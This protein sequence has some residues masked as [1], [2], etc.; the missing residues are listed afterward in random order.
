VL[1]GLALGSSVCAA[2]CASHLPP[3]DPRPAPG[4]IGEET[5]GVFCDRV[6]AQSLHE[7]LSGAS[8]LRV[9]HRD[10]ATGLFADAVDPSQLPAIPA[11]APQAAALERAHAVARIG[12]LARHRADLI[13][14]L[15]AVVPASATVLSRSGGA[16]GACA[17]GEVRPLS[18][19]LAAVLARMS[20]AYDDGTVPQATRSLG[21]LMNAFKA[22]PGAQAA[23]ERTNKRTGYRPE[24]VALGIVRPVLAYPGLRDMANATL[25]LVSPVGP[26]PQYPKLQAL[27]HTTQL[28]LAYASA[29]PYQP[30]LVTVQDA[31]LGIDRLS[32]PRTSLELLSRVMSTEDPAFGG[33]PSRYVVRRDVRGMAAVAAPGGVLPAPF[34]DANGDGLPD[35]DSAG[36]FVTSNGAPAPSP[37]LS[38]EVLADA[39]PRDA[40]GRALDGSGRLVYDFIDT[41]HIY[42]ASVVKNLL[43]M[44]DPDPAMH[45]E[46][47]MDALAGAYVVV[48]PKLGSPAAQKT[49][50][51]G[52][53]LAYDGFDTGHSPLVDLVYAVGQTLADSST[54]AAVTAAAW[55]FTNDEADLAEA[56]DAALRIKKTSDAHPEAVLQ[57]TS[58]LWDDLID[59][60]AQIADVTDD[61]GHPV[62]LEEMLAGLADPAAS[63]LSSTL[64][65]LVSNRD[66]IDYDRRDVNGPPMNV[67]A[68]L[69]GA[70]PQTPVDRT[71]SDAGFN[72][73]VF[74]RFLALIHDTRGVSVCNR[75]GAHVKALM[76]VPVFGGTVD[77][78][79]PDSPLV[80]PFWGKTSFGE[81]EVFKM[82]DMATFYVQ[83][84][85]G[86]AQYVLRDKLLRDG[87][88]IDPADTATTVQLL[89]QSSALTGY[90]PPGTTDPSLRTGF[91]TPPSS[92][93]L[94]TRPEWLNR[95]LFL[96]NGYAGPNGDLPIPARADAFSK[97][98][99]PDHAGTSVCPKREVDDPLSPSDPNYTPGGK[100]YLPDCQDGDWLDQ[101]DAQTIF[102]LETVGFYPAIAPLVRPF[103]AHG[104][105]ELLVALLDALYVH[106][107]SNAD[108]VV[109]SEPILAD[110]FAS[111][112]LPALQ[113]TVRALA[114]QGASFY[115]PCP[116]L[117]A[118]CTGETVSGVRALAYAMRAAVDPNVAAAR[119]LIDRAGKASTTRSDGS[120]K[121][122]VTPIDLVTN[123]LASFDRAF[124]AF[125]AAHSQDT[126]RLA[127]WRSAR[128]QLVDQFLTVD[129]PQAAGAPY[130]FHDRALPRFVPLLTGAL[131]QQL[132]AECTEW[133]SLTCAWAGHDLAQSAADAL[134]SPLAASGFDLLDALRQDPGARV[135][136]EKLLAY[137][138]DEGSSSEALASLLTASA[139][140]MQV[141]QDD[142]NL[143]PILHAVAPSLAPTADGDRGLVDA[144]VALLTRLTSR[145]FDANG[146]E[147]CGSEID[148]SQTLTA[149]L[150]NAVTPTALAGGRTMTPIEVVL[151]A[152]ADV[153]RAQP[154]DAG[155]LASG[156]YA[157]VADEVSQFML[158]PQRGLEQFYAICKN[159][160]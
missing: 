105:P 131:R 13:A 158:D 48:G 80:E 82:D 56:T 119:G 142:A 143:V 87:L 147:Q 60:L 120:V 72:R 66:A 141:L 121:P 14:A 110:A 41:S 5:F 125:A 43:P 17:Q 26:G 9:C 18:S 129:A 61:A 91:W 42:A 102:A 118:A 126:G 70:A 64:V 15:D 68:F 154:D 77:V 132:W 88:P 63:S 114:S 93:L 54:D 152:I 99:N 44:V 89:E 1:V 39:T 45:H 76:T 53:T 97:A 135:E 108:G 117:G 28:E 4:S 81:C 24:S 73:S 11:N 146:V 133:P 59:V 160:H 107:G 30:P 22:S 150:S 83:A 144:Q 69:S 33:G 98:L 38:P 149:V 103:V 36:R 57:P 128:S 19:E 51:D 140:G 79:I 3:P 92:K 109:R 86:Q 49:Y 23:L 16:D 40:S 62:L 100:I 127:Q 148:P 101:R 78:S 67:S 104:H 46:T 29:S 122:Q 50:A 112:L 35:V 12:A 138:L 21:R 94:M 71:Q 153:N 123:A 7:D 65:P 32:R 8:Y 139:D 113:S 90:Q 124:A 159:A 111:N 115:V 6:G 145:S 134:G 31:Q 55:L 58:M 137:L 85:A 106:Y 157:S 130:Q 155:P 151:D 52:T 25:H 74:Q 96:A 27:A 156:D 2:S 20:D 10:P 75:P 34:V 95:N 84:I 47:L 136:L 116:K 37:F